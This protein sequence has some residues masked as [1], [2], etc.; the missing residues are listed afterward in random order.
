MPCTTI[1]HPPSPSYGSC[2]REGSQ[3]TAW[4][5]RT[6]GR[7]SL[8]GICGG[9]AARHDFAYAKSVSDRIGHLSHH[10]RPHPASTWHTLVSPALVL[11]QHRQLSLS[12]FMVYCASTE[13]RHY[14]WPVYS[15][16]T[17]SPA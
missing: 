2:G 17:C 16:P 12:R 6:R 4:P 8:M 15:S 1:R 14:A 13:R 10:V 3:A 9:E 11:E 5:A 7:T